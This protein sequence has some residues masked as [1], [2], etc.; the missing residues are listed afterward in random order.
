MEILEEA[1]ALIEQVL[2]TLPKWMELS[3]LENVNNQSTI[4]SKL[5]LFSND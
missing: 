4:M 2:N 1:T 3:C 5:Y